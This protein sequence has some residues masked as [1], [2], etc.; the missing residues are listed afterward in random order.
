MDLHEQNRGHEH[1]T[2]RNANCGRV[3]A[4]AAI[5]GSAS[6]PCAALNACCEFSNP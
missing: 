2:N 6:T 3:Y 1:T 4:L 5:A